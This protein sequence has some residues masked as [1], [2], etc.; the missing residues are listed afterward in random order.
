[1]NN[2]FNGGGVYHGT[3][4]NE[5]VGIAPY[6]DFEELIPDSIQVEIENIIQDIIIGE[7]DTGWE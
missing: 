1:M 5:G 4:E 6:H 2:S 7:L 3:L